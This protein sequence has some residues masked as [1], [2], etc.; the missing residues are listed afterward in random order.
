MLTTSYPRYSGDFAG[1]F[2]HSLAKELVKG[3]IAVSVVAPHDVNT[4]THE[5]VDGVEIYRFQY[6]LTRK[7][8]RVAYGAGMPD[9][10]AKSVLAKIQLP[11]FMLFFF[12]KGV[13]VA[14][15]CDLIHAQFLLSGVVGAWIKKFLKKNLRLIISARG[16]DV[17]S[18]PTNKSFQL[19]ILKSLNS[20]GVIV[21][22]NGVDLITFSENHFL[23]Q[24]KALR[25]LVWVGRM[26]EVKGLQYLLESLE[27][28]KS[29]VHDGK[30]I[31]VGD[32]PLRAE[33]TFLSR[34][35]KVEELISFAGR[36]EHNKIPDYLH[37][38]LALVL[39]STNE[40]FPNVIYEAMAMGRPV[41][42]TNVGSIQ[43]I[44]KDGYNG[45]LVEPKNPEQLA[46]KIIYVLKNP[47][48]AKEMG[49]NG[50]ETILKLGLT[51]ENT[52][53]KTIAIYKN[54]LMGNGR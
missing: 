34:E 39:S 52:A 33:L 50:K 51:W 11:L 19:I 14:K 28:V 22:P 30:L 32:G 42:S 40:G 7:G 8:Q 13:M 54:L 3:G 47:A 18:I 26:V 17:N 20:A 16:S 12:I 37:D 24:E 9:N 46:E 29:R 25:T 38:S 5:F 44:I 21:I 23:N 6:W 2:I 53:K 31:L 27:I 15:K 41:I 43:D 45:F 1:S 4:K 36:V 35:L 10:I 48:I 49:R